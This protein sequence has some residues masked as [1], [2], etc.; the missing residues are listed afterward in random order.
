MPPDRSLQPPPRRGAAE[1]QA[2]SGGTW[3]RGRVVQV[4]MGRSQRGSARVFVPG[5]KVRRA[6]PVG[7][8]PLMRNGER[9]GVRMERR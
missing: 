7:S 5:R 9:T 4:N 8:V 3:C 6:F 2:R 1:A